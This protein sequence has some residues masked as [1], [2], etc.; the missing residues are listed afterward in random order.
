MLNLKITWLCSLGFY[1]QKIVV[2]LNIFPCYAYFYYDH[3]IVTVWYVV[4]LSCFQLCCVA[5]FSVIRVQS[6]ILVFIKLN[7]IY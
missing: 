7:I 3:P 1:E 6:L 4:L 2:L 5:I